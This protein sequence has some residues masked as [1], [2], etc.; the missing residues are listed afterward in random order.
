LEREGAVVIASEPYD[1][2]EDWRRLPDASVVHASP[3]R[4]EVKPL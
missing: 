3:G 2:G 1:D 4:I